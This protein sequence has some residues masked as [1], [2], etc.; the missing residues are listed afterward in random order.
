MKRIERII[1]ASL[2]TP[3]RKGW[4]LPLLFWAGPGCGKTDI[5]ENIAK[6]YQF[7][8]EVLSPGERG[9][10]AFGVTPVPDQN[11]QFMNYP[12]PE[13][14]GKFKDGLGLVFLDELSTAA[15]AIQPAILGIALARRIGGYYF[16]NRVRIIAAANRTEEAAGGWDLAPPLANR[17]GHM[18][19]EHPNAEE[20]SDWLFAEVDNTDT[21]KIN[22]EDEETMVMSKWAKP[23]AKSRGLVA[24]FIRSRPNLLHS[25]PQMG[26]PNASRAWPSHRT[27]EMATRALTSAM[28][29]GLSENETDEFAGAFIGAGTISEFINYRKEA[30]LPDPDHVLNGQID[31]HHNPKR[32]DRTFAVLGSCT[33]LITSV[34][35]EDRN[36]G[37]DNRIERLLQILNEVA[38]DAIDVVWPSAKMLSNAKLHKYNKNSKELFRRLF[39]TA[40]TMAKAS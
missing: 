39:P 14:V 16:G 27:W 28:I 15:P 38:D 17:F 23:W 8:F 26:N 5:I 37:F 1:H 34:A 6:T 35:K 25:Q 3:T 19:W 40:S 9:E 18:D 32:L 2:F 30:D 24:G 21:L 22:P 20:W 31:F 4:G 36:K 11:G 13:W 29:H 7:P 12:P 33:S 10:G